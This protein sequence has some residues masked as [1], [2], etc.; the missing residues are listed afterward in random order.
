MLAVKRVMRQQGKNL[1]AR[2]LL[3]TYCVH[4]R[5]WVT[6]L[7]LK[8]KQLC[9]T[10]KT[11]NQSR[12]T[13]ILM[14]RRYQSP[15]RQTLLPPPPL[16]LSRPQLSAP[17]VPH[18]PV[19]LAL[20][21]AHDR[22]DLN[23]SISS[24]IRDSSSL[25]KEMILARKVSS[26]TTPHTALGGLC[27]DPPVAQRQRQDPN[28]TPIIDREDD[29]GETRGSNVSNDIAT[30]DISAQSIFQRMGNLKQRMMMVGAPPTPPATAPKDSLAPVTVRHAMSNMS[31]ISDISD[32][33]SAP[34]SEITQGSSA[35]ERLRAKLAANKREKSNY[36]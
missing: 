4:L 34:G 35:M 30:D 15:S 12:T 23:E 33:E 32:I 36:I 7:K 16:V 26:A 19:L 31:D 18:K 22:N 25:T 17:P 29:V 27:V 28:M 2:V 13:Q 10:E 9:R 11:P 3:I 21:E 8:L 14:A 24:P 20:M 1:A 6:Q 5:S